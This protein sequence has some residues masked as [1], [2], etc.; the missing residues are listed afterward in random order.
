M[1]RQECVTCPIR[2]LW[3]GIFGAFPFRCDRCSPSI[4]Q[5]WA[6]DGGIDA[7]CAD[8]FGCF[9]NMLY[10]TAHHCSVPLSF[11]VATTTMSQNKVILQLKM[12][13]ETFPNQVGFKLVSACLSLSL[14]GWATESDYGIS[15]E[16]S[17]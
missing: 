1:V 3:N 6:L 16:F 17:C 4:N 10:I 5:Q 12:G 7:V 15:V 11:V 8:V 14:T 9:D 2:T 13:I